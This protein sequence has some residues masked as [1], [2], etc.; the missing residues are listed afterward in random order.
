MKALTA[1]RLTAA[2]QVAS[3]GLAL[4]VAGSETAGSGMVMVLVTLVAAVA[5][6]PRPRNPKL[7][8]R[9]WNALALLALVL[10]LGELILTRDLLATVVRLVVFLTAFKLFN[11]IAMRDYFVLYMLSFFQ[12]LAAASISYDYRFAIPFALF[13]VTS[14][15]S[16][17]LH[18]VLAGHERERQAGVLVTGC[19]G[20]EE[21]PRLGWRKIAG[22]LGVAAAVL[23]IA[24]LIFPL[25]PRLHTDVI[26]AS[27]AEPLYQVSGF[28][29]VVD[30]D[31]LSKIKTSDK[32]V[33]RVSLS[34]DPEAVRRRPKLRGITLGYFDGRRWYLTGRGG[35]RIRRS[36]DGR[37]YLPE[38]PPGLTID[39]EIIL[40]PLST[41]VLFAAG[42]PEI[43]RGPFNQLYQDREGSL[44]LGRLNYTQIRYTV[45]SSLP[46]YSSDALRGVQAGADNT[47]LRRFTQL[48]LN[49]RFNSQDRKRVWQLSQEITAGSSD[50]LEAMR[51]IERYLRTEYDYTLD[52]RPYRND[53]SKLIAFLFDRRAGH[54]EYF[55]SAM[56][57][58]AR[59]IGV[60]AR[61][62]NGF[63]IGQYNPIGNFYTVR[64]A[65]AHS[66]V[67]IYFPGRGWIDFDPTPSRG[68]LSRFAQNSPDLFSGLLE[69]ID[70]FW[71]QHVLA[72][73]AIDQVQLIEG[74]K[75]SVGAAIESV[76]SA[77]DG[78]L[79]LIP[80]LDMEADFYPLMRLII[81]LLLLTALAALA[82]F[83][84]LRPLLRR[85][86][87][88]GEG[89]YRVPFF[90]RTIKLL[91]KR[92]GSDGYVL[93]PGQTARE[94]A[95][96]VAERPYG[97]LVAEIVE[98]YEQ[99]RFGDSGRRSA[100]RSAG[101][102]KARALEKALR[103]SKLEDR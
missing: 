58:M 54:C 42:R 88:R 51:R 75:N 64:A 77:V 24:V 86:A 87:A 93:Q 59:S 76:N 95:L 38:Q 17:R 39:Q 36:R 72:Y 13:I 48:P 91:R 14:S 19:P 82:W 65:D 84:L 37:F 30:L 101:E 90:E 3:G 29:P 68:Q 50:L 1:L 98:I 21:E 60:P 71:I 5:G 15:F 94:L 57:V 73:D 83:A 103:Q 80:Y 97:R 9:F 10:F 96:A 8:K 7:R 32:V 12:L 20:M 31:A 74:I 79:E 16:L 6:S 66:W 47:T 85:R 62:V 23:G 45:R 100:A 61:L 67:E 78:L 53:R 11:L 34:G 28:S 25:L 44:F 4:A 33:M 35:V 55:A 70:M 18:T 2:A 46:P 63:Q 26:S 41:R 102:A 40:K 22:P 99:I 81:E 56:V 43:L 52:L 27:M 89:R 69:S 92:K 49:K